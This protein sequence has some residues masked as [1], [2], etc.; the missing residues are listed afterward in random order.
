MPLSLPTQSTNE[1]IGPQGSIVKYSTNLIS[2]SY[3][4]I[5]DV[6]SITPIGMTA[7][8]ADDTQLAST[9]QTKESS[10]GWITP[11]TL[12]IDCFLVQ[13]QDAALFLIF[14]TRA[15][16]LWQFNYA[17][18]STQSSAPLLVVGTG[19][20]KEYKPSQVQTGSSDKVHTEFTVQ[21]TSILT[22][23]QGS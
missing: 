13:T 2:P 1:H 4:A 15:K 17:P 8:E 5:T 6:K 22:V 18:L 12:M 21:I 10:P 19:W 9:G 23:T 14:T 11:G 20:I 3:T 7:D 16:A